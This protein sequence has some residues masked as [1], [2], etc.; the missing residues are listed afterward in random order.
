LKFILCAILK[1]FNFKWIFVS[2]GLLNDSVN[3]N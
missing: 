1:K 3:R 2:A